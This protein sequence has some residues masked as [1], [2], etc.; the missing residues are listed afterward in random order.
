MGN[1]ERAEIIASGL[2]Q[3]VGFRYFVRSKAV[4]LGLKGYTKNLYTG[5]VLTEVEGEKFLIE[6]LF[7]LI[8]QGNFHSAVKKATIIW[9]EN[10][11][12]FKDFEI[13]Y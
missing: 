2:V 1:I 8:K 13:R 10:R 12:E 4:S 11:N 7:N 5:E 6:D 9:K 3:G